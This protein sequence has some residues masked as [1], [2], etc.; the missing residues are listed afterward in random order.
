MARN[1]L[2][3]IASTLPRM[4]MSERMPLSDLETLAGRPDGTLSIDL[5][6]REARD[7]SGALVPLQ[8]VHDLAEWLEDRLS[9]NRLGASDLASAHLVLTLRTDAVPTVRARAI[10]FDWNCT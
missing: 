5:L 3:D 2:Q 1:I 10:L 4:I 6:K 7:P 8:I 9:N